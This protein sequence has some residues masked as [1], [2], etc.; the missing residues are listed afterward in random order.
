MCRCGH[1]PKAFLNTAPSLS[2]MTTHEMMDLLEKWGHKSCEIRDDGTGRVN[3]ITSEALTR[4]EQE[5]LEAS[6][7]PGVIVLFTT[8]IKT[9]APLPKQ[10]EKWA[11]DTRKELK[12]L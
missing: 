9:N 8:K 12:K 11:L 2:Q 10:L 1:H 3:V 5:Q 4:T 7:P 6:A